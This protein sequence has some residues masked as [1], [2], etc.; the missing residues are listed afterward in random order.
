M[1]QA[2]SISNK[3]G[4]VKISPLGIGR[5]KQ[6]YTTTPQSLISTYPPLTMFPF[7]LFLSI[8]GQNQ[9]SQKQSFE[10]LVVTEE[11]PD[12]RVQWESKLEE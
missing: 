1:E 6:G 12:V 7:L 5:D 10:S 3:S 8:F 9:I 2:K 11:G 4:F